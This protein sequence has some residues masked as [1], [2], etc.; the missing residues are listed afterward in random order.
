MENEISLPFF[1]HRLRLTPCFKKAKGSDN[2]LNANETLP[3][4]E[5]SM[6]YTCND[7]YETKLPKFRTSRLTEC[8]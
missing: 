7:I 8:V 3:A 1:S 4:T 2:G 5:Q 6:I